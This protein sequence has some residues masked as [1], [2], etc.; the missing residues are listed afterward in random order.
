MSSLSPV[1]G[2]CDP[3]PRDAPLVYTPFCW[4]VSD[5]V[6]LEPGAAPNLVDLAD[7]LSNR[8]SHRVGG[9][10]TLEALGALLWQVG[11]T[12]GRSPS[13]YGFELEQRPV[14]SAG[15]IHPVHV[16]IHESERDYWARYDSR[17]HWLERLVDDRSRLAGLASHAYQ[18]A[19]T[20][21]GTLM[22][23]VAE[24]GRTGAKYE[25]GDSL[26]WRDAGVL[27]GVLCAVAPAVG[28]QVCLLGSTGDTWISNLA[29]Q[30]QLHGVGL[31]YVV[32]LR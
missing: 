19:G 12:L 32:A 26:V 22:A 28:L 24:P 6:P 20:D 27:Q 18:V 1:F 17:N 9:R 25:Y 3:R 21:M 29:E 13:P 23:F 30:G 14:P 16:L 8:R 7:L 2:Q 31:A 5:I 15:A 10:P 11:R 4:P